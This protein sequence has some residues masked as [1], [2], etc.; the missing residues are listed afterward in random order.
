METNEALQ[1]ADRIRQ[2]AIESYH[3]LDSHEALRRA[4]TSRSRP[5]PTDVGGYP[6][7]G[8]YM[9]DP[10]RRLQDN[11]SWSGPGVM[12]CV[13]RDTPILQR[14]W[15]RFRGRVKAFPLEKIRLATLDEVVS[16]HF[17][18]DAL[19]EVEGEL[20]GGKITVEEEARLAVGSDGAPKATKRR[21]DASS[22]SSSSTWTLPQARKV[23]HHRRRRIRRRRSRNA[24]QGLL[25]MWRWLCV[26]LR[27]RAA[28][29]ALTRR[30]LPYPGHQQ[31][32]RRIV[33][34][35]TLAG[36]GTWPKSRLWSPNSTLRSPTR[37]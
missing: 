3:W 27:C 23:K 13:E 17:V 28:M 11:S 1:R 25:M 12:V 24:V 7:R 22:S 5:T 19:K 34:G 21:R 6:R 26:T 10:P 36:R 4:L 8:H 32:S 16:A 15:V 33:G 9:F 30:Y 14:V 35:T 29:R 20:Q 31:R 18:N 2:K 37:C